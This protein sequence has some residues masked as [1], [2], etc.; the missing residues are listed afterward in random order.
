MRIISIESLREERRKQTIET[1]VPFG[2]N[3]ELK[4]VPKKIVNG[5]MEIYRL[6]KPMGEMI[7]T[8]DG[9]YDVI[10][11][12]VIDLE[13]GR[14]EVPLI[15]QAIYRPMSDPNFSEHVDI[16]PL[17]GQQC[18]FLEKM[19]LEEVK[20]GTKKIGPKDTVPI[21]TYAT[22]FQITEDMIEYDKTWE[23][24]EQNRSIGEAYNA[25]LNH[26]HLYPIIN[27]SYAAKNKTAAVS[28]KSTLLEN[29][30]ETFR[31]ALIHSFADKNTDTKAPRKP[32]VLLA[33]SVRKLD[34]EE[35]LQRMQVAGT[36]YP[37]ISIDTIVY[38]DGW[39][40]T[41]GEKTYTYSGVDTNKAYL[42]E[43]RRYFRELIKHDLRVD[44]DNAD[45][46]R[47][48]EKQVVARVRRGV[49]A[50]PANA[51]EEITLPTS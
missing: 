51:V 43:P 14:E 27:F 38:Y 34:I 5:E 42:V 48:I 47:L 35:C 16:A 18:V 1:Q 4:T 44:A 19:E 22:G 2:W 10:Q 15:Y 20:F 37:S 49:V 28:T 13:L 39:S 46:S 45:L 8:P 12:S 41:V 30:R 21:I 24:E 7:G 3:G 50:Y 33:P 6:N 23:I 32:T 26:I 36:I 17:I 29:M 31:N 11:K 25:L 40:V 9:L